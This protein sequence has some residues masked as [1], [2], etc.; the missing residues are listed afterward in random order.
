MARSFTT[1][2]AA[3]RKRREVHGPI[4]RTREWTGRRGVSVEQVTM[5]KEYLRLLTGLRETK[6]QL[7]VERK[8][9][10][11]DSRNATIVIATKDDEVAKLKRE[12]DEQARELARKSAEL[13]SLRRVVVAQAR[14]IYD[15][16]DTPFKESTIEG[17]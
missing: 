6:A 2:T 10:E 13:H 7:E 8:A 12:W 16:W 11:L 17:A 4:Q 15:R 9:R 14:R 3:K 1:T 5:T